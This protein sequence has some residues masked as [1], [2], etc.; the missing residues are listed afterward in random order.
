MQRVARCST[1]TWLEYRA[2]LKRL[3]ICCCSSCFG[4]G[5]RGYSLAVS[6]HNSKGLR[7]NY[8]L[9][10]A[11]FET[12]AEP[13]WIM[14]YVAKSLH[15]DFRVNRIWHECD[16]CSNQWISGR[17]WVQSYTLYHVFGRVVLWLRCR[18]TYC[19]FRFDG[20]PN[21]RH[22]RVFPLEASMKA[23]SPLLLYGNGL[24]SHRLKLSSTFKTFS[25]AV[26]VDWQITVSLRRNAT[27]LATFRNDYNK[28]YLLSY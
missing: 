4:A 9:S 26:S 1:K 5:D 23:G 13:S 16:N 3:W 25:M 6:N 22:K 19:R 7:Q 17:L 8:P 15:F 18:A 24:P 21:Y 11:Y 10:L 20:W 28:L 14:G 12:S 27:A 2:P